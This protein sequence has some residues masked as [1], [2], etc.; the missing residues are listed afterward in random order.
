[1]ANPCPCAKPGGDAACE[2][3]SLV[4]RRYQN[5]LSGPLMDRV[6]L[7]VDLPA[8]R[9]GTLLDTIAGESSADVARR[10]ANARAMAAGRRRD[11][12]GV[13]RVRWLER[14]GPVVDPAPVALPAAAIGVAAVDPAG[15]PGCAVGARF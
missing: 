15:R 8:V 11:V 7:Q 14:D 9:S 5:R 10:V 2:C 13:A 1:A 4:R 3:S 12:G 6:D